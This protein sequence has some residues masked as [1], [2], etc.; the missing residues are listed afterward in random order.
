MIISVFSLMPKSANSAVPMVISPVPTRI[1]SFAPILSSAAPLK[2]PMSAFSPA[3][4][5]S[6]RP[7]IMDAH[8]SV[9]CR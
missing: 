2:G 9:T 4:G 8:S 3:P 5:S 1:V 6:M 7:A